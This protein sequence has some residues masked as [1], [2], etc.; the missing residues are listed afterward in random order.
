MDS[1]TSAQ[2]QPD[3]RSGVAGTNRR[4]WLAFG[5]V[6]GILLQAAHQGVL[7]A[8]SR[9]HTR[10]AHL[11]TRD[12]RQRLFTHF[13]ALT[14]RHHSQL[15][16]GELTYRLQFDATFLERLIVGGVLPL[17]FSAITLVVMFAILLTIDWRLA[18]V[19]LTIVPFLFVWIRWSARRIRPRAER[20]RAAMT[21]CSPKLARG[22]RA[23]SVSD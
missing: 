17:L 9:L 23:A 22:C 10:T 3:R 21:R 15:P 5:V 18:L 16:V 2:R 19:S 14:L 11:L 13:Q 20:S 12:L 4:G 7:M 1:D 8:H 6:A